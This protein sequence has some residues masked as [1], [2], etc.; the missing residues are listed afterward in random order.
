MDNLDKPIEEMEFRQRTTNA[1]I[2]AG[3][4][5][6]RDIVVAKQSEIKKISGLGSKSFNEIRDVII[7]YGYHF[8]MQI[9][10]SANHYQSYEKA[11]Q[12]IEKLGKLLEQR[13][14]FIVYNNL[15]EAFKTS[16]EEKENG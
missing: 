6:L 7:F 12:E 10:K 1:L 11:L 4:K 14:S 9:L 15:W 13:D 2:Q 3:Y 16:L 8:D 5:T